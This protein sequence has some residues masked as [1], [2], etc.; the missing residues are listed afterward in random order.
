MSKISP[1]SN[2]PF[3][4]RK[5]GGEFFPLMSRLLKGDYQCRDCAAKYLREWDAKR[6]GEPVGKPQRQWTEEEDTALAA[7]DGAIPGRSLQA[8]AKRRLRKGIKAKE[9]TLWTP[10][11]DRLLCQMAGKV[12]LEELA[13]RYLI[14]RSPHAI[15]SRASLRGLSV[16]V[17]RP[18]RHKLTKQQA[19]MVPRTVEAAVPRTLPA[20]V[21]GEVV[22]SLS[23][24]VLDGR[25]AFSAIAASV[26]PFV[27]QAYAMFPNFGAHLSLDE[28]LFDDGP[29][30]LGDQIDSTAFR[31]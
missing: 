16:R 2:L 24:A 26:K 30:T 1:R 5:C 14:G 21:R 23:M 12:P 19:A 22:Q 4:C 28:P 11:E 18:K 20:Q 17:K 13:E 3:T 10:E 8:C 9:W 27:T 29:T 31:F 7:C 25:V 6:R 15:E